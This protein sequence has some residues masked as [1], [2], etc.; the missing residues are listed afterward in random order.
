MSDRDPIIE[1][2]AIRN[3]VIEAAIASICLL[4]VGLLWFGWDRV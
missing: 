1:K 2:M 3:A 4:G